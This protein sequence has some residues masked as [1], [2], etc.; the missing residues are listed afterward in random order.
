MSITVYDGIQLLEELGLECRTNVGLGNKNEEE[1]NQ[2]S[3]RI[4]THN[5]WTTRDASTSE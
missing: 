4:R 1:I 5:L 2:A 3:G